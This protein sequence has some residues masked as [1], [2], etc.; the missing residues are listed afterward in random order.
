V[1]TPKC[2]D[3]LYV[4]VFKNIITR[5]SFAQFSIITPFQ[6]SNGHYASKGFDLVEFWAL[7]QKT[8]ALEVGFPKKCVVL[9]PKCSNMD[10]IVG[11]YG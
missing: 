3:N 6:K 9:D 10:P 2:G 5:S 8:I 7:C 1:L 11:R 4:P